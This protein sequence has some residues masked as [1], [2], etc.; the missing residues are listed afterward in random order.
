[1]MLVP[2]TTFANEINLDDESREVIKAAGY[3]ADYVAEK[4]TEVDLE[5]AERP[6]IDGL[7]GF[8]ENETQMWID[9]ARELH[10]VFVRPQERRKTGRPMADAAQERFYEEDDFGGDLTIPRDLS[11]DE[12]AQWGVE[13]MGSYNYRPE[14]WL[15]YFDNADVMT[16][17]Q[18][19]A[20][21]NL[22]SGYDKLPDGTWSGTKRMLKGTLTSPSTYLGIGTLGTA[23][24]ARNIFKELGK[25]GVKNY[26]KSLM[27]TA[28]ASG[29]EGGLYTGLDD[30]MRQISAM[31]AGAQEE[32]DIGR[33]AVS[34]GTGVAA[35]SVLATG[36]PAAARG[37]AE[38]VRRLPDAL[39][40]GVERMGGG[41]TL[42]TGMGPV[43]TPEDAI[44]AVTKEAVKTPAGLSRLIQENPDGFTVDLE[45]GVWP[46]EGFVV[47]PL[48]RTEIILDKAEL[49][50]DVAA[51]LIDNVVKMTRIT[52]SKVYAGGW[53]HEGKY[54]LDASMIFDNEV[55]ALYA[56]AAGRQIG[57]FDLGTFN[58]IETVAGFKGL[59]ESGTFDVRR[60]N[61]QRAYSAELDE[62][63]AEAGIQDAATRARSGENVPEISM[64]PEGARAHKVP[65]N[66]LMTGSGADPQFKVTQSFSAANKAANFSAI[67]QAKAAHPDALKSPENWA[68]FEQDTLGGELLP[69]P[70]MEAIR[71]A[72]SPDAMAAK[73]NQLSEEM[74][75]GVDEG[76]ANVSVLRDMYARGEA[77]PEVTANLFVWGILS[78]GAGPVQQESAYVDII[79]DAG[80]LIRKAVDGKFTEADLAEWKKISGSLSEGS[81]GKQVTM[82]VNATGKLL[83]ELGKKPEGSDQTVLETLHDMIGNT[84]MT[85]AQI[86]RKFMELT[87]SAGIDNKVV[88]FILLVS[89]R[90]DVLVMDRIQSRHLWDDGRFEGFNIYDGYTKAGTTAKEGLQGIMRGPRGLLLT[91]ALEDGLRNNV[92]EAYRL[93]GR[94]RDASLGRFHWESWV[95][96]GEQVVDHETL[97]AVAS[98]DPVG[99]GVSEG[100]P[101]TFSSGMRYM[102]GESGT[103]VEYPVSD[104]SVVYMT[105][106]RMKEFEKYVKNAK[107]GIVPSKF[108]VTERT[109]VRW[110]ERPEVDRD[111]LDAA[112]REFAN[113]D[114]QGKTIPGSAKP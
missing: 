79:D 10:S 22:L 55:D 68:A 67:D 93:V 110:F 64:A 86:R 74:K 90:D 33:S 62:R 70:P 111:K 8:N 39:S 31:D 85:A 38:G 47:A 69:V 103:V 52:G 16:Q 23:F 3:D 21:Y 19:V 114:A 60:F 63:A 100:K 41:R 57:L 7:P 113:A 106:T 102:R 80:D 27:P 32:F 96:D 46:S 88:S 50:D 75:A 65:H 29:V 14:E 1:M 84:D 95:I 48:K 34:T 20:F 99:V 6:I 26:L 89:G 5:A 73:L 4:D 37:V 91:E 107:N 59:R 25:T 105:P 56:A 71:Y 72:Q 78:R 18:K 51:E 24:F 54:Y 2:T 61:E 109:D 12:I 9:S 81:P 76:F 11:D 104:G 92:A 87:E 66:L 30:A 44:E 82:N 49:N 98:K 40:A 43:D 77:D 13:F 35:G 101:G 97:K 15:N 112:A 28:I 53:L 36:L 83:L 94:E 17:R 42:G 108:K 45:T 58:E